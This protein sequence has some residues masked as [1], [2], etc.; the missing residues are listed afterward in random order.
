MNGNIKTHNNVLLE[1]EFKN[2]KNFAQHIAEFKDYYVSDKHFYLA[3]APE[4]FVNLI[5]AHLN[6]FHDTEIQV[7]QPFLRMATERL[8]ADWRIH[9]DRHVGTEILPTN[10][11]VYYITENN[12]FKNGTAFWKHKEIGHFMPEQFTD[13]QK[14]DVLRFDSNNINQWELQDV[15]QGVENTMFTYPCEYFHSKYPRQAWGT[16]PKDCRLVFIMF[17]KL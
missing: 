1:D 16:S 3:Q 14:D 4:D 13:K 6:A 8:D 17:Y 5:T 15:V 9:C 10:A 7:V 12:T 2:I 11:L